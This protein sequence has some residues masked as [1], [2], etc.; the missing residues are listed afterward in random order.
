MMGNAAPEL[1]KMTIIGAGFMGHNI[2]AAALSAD[3]P[4]T[5]IDMQPKVLQDA[6]GKIGRILRELEEMEMI[7]SGGAEEKMKLLTPGERL[8]DGLAGSDLVLESIQENLSSKQALLKAIDGIGAEEGTLV[9]TNTS[10]FRISELQK[11]RSF[12]GRFLGFHWVN[13]PYLIPAVEIIPGEKTDP[14]TVER[15]CGMVRRLGKVPVVSGDAPGFIVNRLQLAL[16]NEAARMLEEGVASPRDIENGI[17]LSIGLRL[18]FFGPFGSS[19]FAASKMTLLSTLEYLAEQI[20][21]QFAPTDRLRDMVAR[22][23][24]GFL[25]GRGWLDYS[26]YDDRG[27]EMALKRRNELIARLIRFLKEEGVLEEPFYDYSAP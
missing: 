16:L 11:G 1:R 9:A 10:S 27:R 18:P 7:P 23:D 17:R 6:V 24:I 22:G 14:A 5:L 20:G 26:R 19:D 3:V 25:A 2:A 12:A 15:A 21:P 4:V 13:P 8:E